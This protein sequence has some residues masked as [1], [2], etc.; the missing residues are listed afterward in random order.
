MMSFEV[1]KTNPVLVAEDD[2]E[3][4]VVEEESPVEE[5][6]PFFGLFDGSDEF[7]LLSSCGVQQV[8]PS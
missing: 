1:G 6:P 8:K 5:E 4:V 7:H 3:L 2:P